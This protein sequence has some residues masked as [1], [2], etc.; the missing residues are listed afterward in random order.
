MPAT[1]NY[2]IGPFLVSGETKVQRGLMALGPWATL[3]LGNSTRERERGKGRGKFSGSLLVV[4][5]WLSV[6]KML[7]ANAGWMDKELSHFRP[8]DFTKK[9]VGNECYRG[10]QMHGLEEEEFPPC[11]GRMNSRSQAIP[12]GSVQHAQHTAG[13]VTLEGD[14]G[15]RPGPS[16]IV[17]VLP[18]ALCDFWVQTLGNH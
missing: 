9:A 7:I 17:P 2:E 3:S 6:E 10:K 5:L 8:M 18:R 13:D 14:A 4:Y 16:I 1:G 11:E 12:G 15:G